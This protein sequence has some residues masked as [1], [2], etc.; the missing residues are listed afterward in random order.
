M[1]RINQKNIVKY[2]ILAPV[3]ALSTF[4]GLIVIIIN[5]HAI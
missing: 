4:Y 3:V 5:E 1:N 2:V